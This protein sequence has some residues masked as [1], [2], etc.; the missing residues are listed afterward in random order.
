[1]AIGD[2]LRRTS[3]VLRHLAPH[4]PGRIQRDPC[5]EG[6]AHRQ[7]SRSAGPRSRALPPSDSDD[8]GTRPARLARCRA[9][10]D[11]TFGAG[12]VRTMFEVL[13]RIAVA[14]RA[15]ITDRPAYAQV[16]E[17]STA[18]PLIDVRDQR[19]RKP[20]TG[21][22]LSAGSALR[23]AGQTCPPPTHRGNQG[24]SARPVPGAPECRCDPP[25]PEQPAAHSGRSRQ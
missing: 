17:E 4:L 2:Q 22:L 15:Q 19:K 7:G 21:R 18:F 23:L 24:T 14:G 13:R 1:M 25:R 5:R 12:P 16:R 3:R 9:W 10:K 6:Q 20:T 8:L 11:M